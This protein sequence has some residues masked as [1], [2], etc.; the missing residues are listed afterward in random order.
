[1]TNTKIINA[2]VLAAAGSDLS[3]ATKVTLPASTKQY[4]LEI[5]ITNGATPNGNNI[6]KPQ[7]RFATS[8]VDGVAATMA[9]QLEQNSQFKRN[10]IKSGRSEVTQFTTPP[11][12]P[13]GSILYV[14]FNHPAL[15]AAASV[16]VWLNTVDEAAGAIPPASGASTTATLVEGTKAPAA[17]ATPEALAATNLVT[18]V[19]IR[20]GRTARVANTGSVWIGFSSTND[21][22]LIELVP[23]ATITIDAPYGKYIDLASIY[24]DSVTLGDGVVFLAVK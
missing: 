21:S 2:G 14:W 6:V 9:A 23:G 19:L 4:T 13:T 8:N 12:V 20:A 1:M 17:I 18:S 5:V 16:D 15:G 22:Q 3:N 7:V 24:V 10:D 11:F